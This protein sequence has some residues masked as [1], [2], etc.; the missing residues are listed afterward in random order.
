MVTIG[1][2]HPGNN[3]QQKLKDWSLTNIHFLT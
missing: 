3:P 1:S 2:F